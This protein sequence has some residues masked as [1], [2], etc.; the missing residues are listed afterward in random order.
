MRLRHGTPLGLRS[1]REG[2]AIRLLLGCI[3]IAIASSQAAVAQEQPEEYFRLS[4][5]SRKPIWLHLRATHPRSPTTEWQ[6][7]IKVEP[8]M[9]GSYRLAGYEPFDILI[10]MSD[11][12]Q[13]LAQRVEICTWME[14]CRRTGETDYQILFRKG[15]SV[16][17]RFRYDDETQYKLDVQGDGSSVRVDLGLVQYDPPRKPRLP[18]RIP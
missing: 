17:G 11:G 5:W 16:G 15:R 7:P 3:L 10:S 13:Y 2:S 6:E 9:L 18:P 1:Q 4:N 8:G 12:T 14:N